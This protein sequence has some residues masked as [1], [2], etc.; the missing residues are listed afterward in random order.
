MAKKTIITK[1][2]KGGKYMTLVSVT[3]PEIRHK[4][5]FD[6][7][8]IRSALIAELDAT[9]LYQSHIDNLNS[10]DAKKVMEHIM[11]EEK[12]HI[13]E[14][15]C[16]LMKLDKDQEEKMTEVNVTTCIAG[17]YQT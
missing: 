2:I 10:Q 7:E 3:K 9:S 14:L 6:Q 16:L 17:G 11:L 1:I 4:E 5:H 15:Q 12:E 13:S 8:L